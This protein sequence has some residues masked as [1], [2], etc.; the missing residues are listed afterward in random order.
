MTPSNPR[1]GEMPQ[2]RR[3]PAPFDLWARIGT[4]TGKT[5]RPE[6]D[7]SSVAFPAITA[8]AD[9]RSRDVR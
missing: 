8:R 7:A 9:G 3:T 2:P 4:V 6:P 1:S 5:A